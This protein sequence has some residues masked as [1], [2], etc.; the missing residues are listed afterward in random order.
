M[1]ILYTDGACLPNPG[2]GGWGW[3]DLNGNH[4][5]G[6][7]APSTNQ[8]MELT[9][10]IKAL[11]WYADQ[12]NRIGI[13]I[14]TDSQYAIYSATKWR[15]GWED[16]GYTTVNGDPLKNLDLILKLH[17][18]CDFATPY[19]EWVKGHSGN[20]GNEEADRLAILGT[21]CTPEEI[22][23]AQK[24]LKKRNGWS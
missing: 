1:R 20:P 8:R 3:T 14:I 24:V 2:K 7:E 22:A 13:K 12:E 15:A 4:G 6:G 19:F 16:R 9:A 10:T 21:G 11:E 5:H 18:L 17:E 23:A